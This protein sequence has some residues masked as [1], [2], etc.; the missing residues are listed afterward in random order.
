[1]LIINALRENIF[2]L[3]EIKQIA[4]EYSGGRRE[5]KKCIREHS[6]SVHK[7]Y[8]LTPNTFKVLETLKF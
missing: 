6:P 1:M 5:I 4:F 7:R 2:C 3:H 8:N